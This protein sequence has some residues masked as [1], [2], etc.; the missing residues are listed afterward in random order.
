MATTLLPS[1]CGTGRHLPN[2]RS[3]TGQAAGVD[4]ITALTLYPHYS[5]ATTGSSLSH[6]Q[7]NQQRLAPDI[8]LTCISSWPTQN[9]YI[10]AVAE[11]IKQ[12]CSPLI[13]A[14]TNR[15]QRSQP[16]RL[17]YQGR[18][19]LRRAYRTI[20]HGNRKNHRST[21]QTLLPEPEW[22]G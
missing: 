18:R 13:T 4:R 22:S 11:N 14:R 20:H 6:L 12:D 17:F 7:K 5:K 8:P 3:G 10:T 1:L 2:R 21:G 19:S 16:P 15:L 9:E